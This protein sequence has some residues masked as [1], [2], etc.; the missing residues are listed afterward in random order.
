[1]RGR[2]AAPRGAAGNRSSPSRGPFRP[3]GW[4]GL[5]IS[6]PNEKT[7][8]PSPRGPP[9]SVTADAALRVS[10][11]A[12]NAAAMAPAESIALLSDAAIFP[13]VAPHLLWAYSS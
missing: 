12:L 4:Q 1:R 3:L 7:H 2:F 10:L 11:S 13:A 9:R 5:N 6:G 8:L